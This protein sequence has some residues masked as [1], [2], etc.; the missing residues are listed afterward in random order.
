MALSIDVHPGDD[1]RSAK[2]RLKGDLDG[3][4]ARIARDEL[5]SLFERGRVDVTLDLDRVGFLDS[6]GLAT[7]ISALR[8]AR[9]RGGDV[10]VRT[11]NRRIRRVLEVTA[12]A[13]V[14]KLQPD[15]A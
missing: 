10:R 3:D 1:D 5:A 12:L 2:V 15:A 13:Q 9:E 8:R 4:G 7:L 14:F 6:S 11:T